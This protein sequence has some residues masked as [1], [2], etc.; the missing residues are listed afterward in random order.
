MY[1]IVMLHVIVHSNQTIY[2]CTK[3]IF[4]NKTNDKS[5]EKSSLK[6]FYSLTFKQRS[7]NLTVI[8]DFAC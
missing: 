8:A 3:Q 4:V 5:I 2:V 7:I 1:N 6:S